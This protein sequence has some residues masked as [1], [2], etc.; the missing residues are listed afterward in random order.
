[1]TRSPEPA[2]LRRGAAAFLP[3]L[4]ERTEF[5]IHPATEHRQ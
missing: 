2:R 5:P 1:M 3:D 4:R